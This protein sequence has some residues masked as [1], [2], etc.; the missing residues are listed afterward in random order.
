MKLITNPDEFFRELKD[1]EVRIRKPLVI[2]VALAA[3][4]SAYQYFLVTKLSQAFPAEIA[5]FF[6]V[7]ACIGIIGSFI[8][9]FA[10]WL[11]L[12]VI[13]HGLSAFFNGEGSFRRT[14]EFVGYGF[15]PSLVGS[16]ITVPMSW[17]Y[18]S[19]AEVPK[20]SIA[21]LQQNPKVVKS[22]MLSIIPKDLVYSNII[23][24]VAVT[25]WSL[26]IW[27]F[28]I[29]HAREIELR[30]AFI[31]A[32]IPTLLFGVYQVWSILKLL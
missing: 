1:K 22:I 8:G 25:A 30:K 10:V 5:K 24:N 19:Q 16:A 21:Q 2:V 17:Y 23:I 18:V 31:C 4:I 12:A 20:I 27:T 32:L 13:M 3:L 28:A 29:K 15:F 14:F 7:G 6:V 11:I 9:M 26:T